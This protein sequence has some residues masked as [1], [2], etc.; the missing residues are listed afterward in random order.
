MTNLL[1]QVRT[2][3]ERLSISKK[4]G[5]SLLILLLG[6]GLGIL[7]KWL[8]N[9]TINDTVWWQNILSVLDLRNILSQTGIWIF[10]AMWIAVDSNSPWR[11]SINVLLFFAGMCISYHLYTVLF[12]G[13]NPR[14]YML[15]WYAITIISPILAYICWYAKGQGIVSLVLKIAICSV[16]FSAFFSIGIWYFGFIS[17]IDTGL[18]I[19]ALIILYDTPHNLRYTL[20]CSVVLAYVISYIY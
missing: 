2:P 5:N 3:N 10:I 12:A 8:D 20:I 18:F 1:Q 7:S 16:L 15:I 13:F 6:I 9:M 17:V 19:I 11:G 14:S 4:I